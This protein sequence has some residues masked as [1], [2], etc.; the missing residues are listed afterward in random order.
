MEHSLLYTDNACSIAGCQLSPQGCPA[1]SYKTENV[2]D[3]N[4]PLVRSCILNAVFGICRGTCGQGRAG[5][6]ISRDPKQH[7]GPWKVTEAHFE[8]RLR[9]KLNLLLLSSMR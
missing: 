7:L 3:V 9:P 1:S 8:E 4:K 2:N 6:V 5:A